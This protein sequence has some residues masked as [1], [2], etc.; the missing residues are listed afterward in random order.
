MVEN[1][2]AGRANS[3]L[4]VMPDVERAYEL[5][6]RAGV[7]VLLAAGSDNVSYLAGY[8]LRS[9]VYLP[10][11][12]AYVLLSRDSSISPVIIPAGWEA[13][14]AEAQ[15]WIK[16]VRPYRLFKEE[17][18]SS[19]ASA[20]AEKGLDASRIGVEYQ[21]LP[22]LDYSVLSALLPKAAL[23][24]ADDLFAQLRAVKSPPELNLMRKAARICDKA[25]SA[26]LT[27]ARVGDT[28]RDLFRVLS[29]EAVHQGADLVKAVQLGAGERASYIWGCYPSERLLETGDIVRIDIVVDV[30]GYNSD[31]Q[32]TAVVGA[33]TERQ[34]H[35]YDVMYRGVE[36]AQSVIRPGARARDPFFAAAKVFEEAGEAFPAKDVG[37]GLGLKLHEAPILHPENDQ[38]LEEG[39]CLTVETALLGDGMGVE[40]EVIVTGDGCE[41]LTDD[42]DHSGIFEISSEPRSMSWSEKAD[43]PTV[44]SEAELALT[45]E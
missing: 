35:L 1:D 41:L 30:R 33:P 2:G 38:E 16:D 13:R 29:D 28:E 36:A 9:R 34:R 44:L 3:N 4:T 18:L 43:L 32:R 19:V 23:V 17:P 24:P 45:R 12:A 15:S 14:D 40:D 37:H 42:M 21:F 31:M 10:R 7:D 39:M 22:A 27:H 25:I 11:R 6:D 26:S 5:M 8:P 20:L